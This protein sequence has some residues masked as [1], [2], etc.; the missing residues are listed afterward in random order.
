MLKSTH[1]PKPPSS[2]LAPLPPGWT[3]HIAATGHAYYS[4]ATTKQS[5]YARP[6]APPPTYTQEA[7]L[8]YAVSPLPSGWTEHKAPTGHA[9]YY[10]TTTNQSTYMRPVAPP[11]SYPQGV[12]PL[13][14]DSAPPQGVDPPG[15]PIFP[16]HTSVTG[17]HSNALF[18]GFHGNPSGPQFPYRGGRSRGGSHRNHKERDL[19]EDRPKSKQA[20]P[21][22]EPWLLV[23]TKL[24]RRFFYHP[25]NGVSFWKIPEELKEGVE[26][27]D[28]AELQRIKGG[29]RGEG[30]GGQRDHKEESKTEVSEADTGSVKRTF[31]AVDEDDGEGTE[32]Y[33][34]ADESD[35]EDEDNSAK[36]RRTWGPDQPV[37]F[38]ED[39]IAWQLAAMGEDYGELA[40]AEGFGESEDA[41]NEPL[42]EDDSKGLFKDMLDD[43][44][45]SP[46][47]TW[48]KVIEE[49]K[50]V[51][52]ERYKILPNMK[53]RREVWDEWSK[54]KIQ[55]LKELKAK[56][57]KKDPRIPYL[58]FLQKHATLKLYW[59][60][61]KR[62]YKK[63]P[64]MRE[65]K[66]SDKDREK[67]YRDYISRLK[68]PLS[69]LT[70]DLSALLKAIPLSSL[71][72]STT[73]DLLPLALITDI[74]YISVPPVSR[75][76]LIKA[77]IS[78]LPAPLL[79]SELEDTEDIKRREERERRERALRE[80]EMV[81]LRERMRVK[82]EIEMGKGRLRGEEAQL[83]QAMKVGKEGL[84]GQLQASSV[85]DSPKNGKEGTNAE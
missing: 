26:R 63:E 76:P 58:E 16:A 61:F 39:D 4:N 60:E 47:S 28:K 17:F 55:K 65:S 38:N 37:E 43:C 57:E 49:G 30:G 1:K 77:Y 8:S 78:T 35:E 12:S 74:R 22:C 34:E 85:I 33:E 73:I 42:T 9:Y 83:E 5:T 67:W 66:L 81:V 15:F 54:E 29:Q 69:T 51:E 20:I 79:T 6:V 14:P 68:L 36:R 11:Q 72:R 48:E 2:D 32:E 59:P 71:N 53:S 64:E 82:G 13:Y 31:S 40:E 46:Y 23:N 10:N 62:K 56:T 84:L 41:R 52:D 24:G 27:F 50:V 21:G 80:R 45:I 18:R 3:E 19:P 44:L 7:N 75:D 70:H 25:K